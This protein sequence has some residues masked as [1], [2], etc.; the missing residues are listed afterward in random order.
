MNEPGKNLSRSAG[1][2]LFAVF[3][4]FGGIQTFAGQAIPFERDK[5][6]QLVERMAEELNGK[7]VF[8][9]IAADLSKLLLSRKK[10]Y[11]SCSSLADLAKKMES[12]LFALSHDKHLHIMHLPSHEMEKKKNPPLPA[13]DDGTE[14]QYGL[15]APKIMNGQIGYLNITRMAIEREAAALAGRYLNELSDCKAI[16]IDIRENRG[17]AAGMVVFLASYFFPEPIHFYSEYNRLKDEY[18]DVWTFRDVFGKRPDSGIP[19]YILTSAR[20]F[21]AAEGFAYCMKHYKRAI[22]VGENTSGGAH[23]IIWVKLPLD[24]EMSIPFARIIHPMTGGDWEGSGVIPHH[25][26]QAKDA[27]QKTVALITSIS[28]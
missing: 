24:F 12:D 9:K 10:V 4:L 19:L 2:I 5:K 1:K 11:R 27:L 28:E 23:P 20:T 16:I 6:D 25:Q 8:P 21:S 26:V 7:Y 22:I 3:V 15:S 13:N 17:G 18:K 14:N